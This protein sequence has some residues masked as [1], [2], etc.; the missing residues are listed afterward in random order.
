MNLSKQSKWC[1][2]K[3]CD[4]VIETK[5]GRA[6]DCFCDCGENFCFSCLKK[7][8]TPIDCELLQTWIDRIGGD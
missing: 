7:A 5:Y 1:P 2:G 3:Q 4:R 6:I 8:H